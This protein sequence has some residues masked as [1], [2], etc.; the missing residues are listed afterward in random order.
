[1]RKLTIHWS[2]YG[3]LY[4]DDSL[5]CLETNLTEL[6]SV[7]EDHDLL[8]CQ[9]I[10]VTLIRTMIKEGKIKFDV[11]YLTDD[12]GRSWLIN[13]EGRIET[14]PDFLTV[15]DRLLERLF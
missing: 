1:M 2:K 10:V 3:H 9:D 4:G 5:A 15:H 14:W 7:G 8:V 12:A 6:L 13:R 11:I